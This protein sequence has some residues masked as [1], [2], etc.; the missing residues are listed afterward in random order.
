MG[1][2]R[3]SKGSIIPKKEERL[4]R[5]TSIMK[6]GFT[7]DEYV[8]TFKELYSRFCQRIVARYEQHERLTKAGKSHP[9]PYPKRYLL[10]VSK[11]YLDEVREKH[12]QGIVLFKEERD[13]IIEEIKIDNIPRKDR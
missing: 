1:R 13:K 9:M 3:V 10:N 7:D 6:I 11:K 5:I 12:E 4:R 2:K 8:D